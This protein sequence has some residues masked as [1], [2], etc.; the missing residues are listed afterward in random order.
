ML[1][2]VIFYYFIIL[3]CFAFQKMKLIIVLF[4]YYFIL[5]FSI[6]SQLSEKPKHLMSFG[7][8]R[9]LVKAFSYLGLCSKDKAL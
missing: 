6:E 4:E 5:I 9:S 2:I 1:I 8:A 3:F 7:L